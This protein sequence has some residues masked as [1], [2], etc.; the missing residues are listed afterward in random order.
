MIHQDLRYALRTWAARPAFAVIAILTLALG[1]GANT[2]IFSLWN[3]VLYAALPG[4]ANPEQLVMLSN[5]NA[6]GSWTGRWNSR[7]DGPRAWVTYEEFERLR[8]NASAFAALMATQSSL[9]TWRASIDG[10]PVE[11]MRGRLVSG[12]FFDLLGARAAIGRLFTIAEDSG[13]PSIA[14]ISHAFWQQRFGGRPDVLGKTLTIRDTPVTIVGV[15]PPRFVGET[16]AQLPDLWMPLRLQPRVLPPRDWLRDTPPDKVMWL[17]VFGRLKPGVTFAHAE[18][19]ANAIL[20]SSLETFYGA[21]L[22]DRRSEFL[23]QQLRLTAAPSGTT[24]IRNE[25]SASL[26]MLLASVGVLMLIACANLANLLLA[27][28]AA[29]QPE[30]AVRLSLGASRVRLVRQLVTES[31]ALAVMGAL[32]GLGVAYGLHNALV[33]ML[34]GADPRFAMAFTITL[35][36]AGFVVAATLA[37]A[38]MFGL[39]PAWQL[40]RSDLGARLNERGR[41][42]G[43][44]RRE[45]R[46]GRWL[47]GAQ[48][49]LS[50]P[51]LVGAGLLV[52][53]VYNLQR[54]DLGFERDGLLLA[55]VDLGLVASDTTR[56]DRVLRDVDERLGRI[57]GVQAVSFSQLG[58]F[59]GGQSTIAIEVEGY[60]WPSNT[61]RE[62][63]L[64][65]VG[66]DYM[67]TLG[68]PIRLGRDIRETDARDTP[69][70]CVVNEAFAR[71][72]FGGRHPLGLRVTTVDDS[73][74]RKAYEVVGMAGDARMHDLRGEV[75]PRFYLPA[76]QRNSQGTGRTF[77]IRS[78]GALPPASGSIRETIS[79]VDAALSVTSIV[80]VDDQLA[81][82]TAQDRTSAMLATAFGIVALTLAAIGLYGVLSYAVARR[83]SEIAIRIA[84]G[85]QGGR[86]IAMILRESLGVVLAGL[87][88]GGALA[89][90][91][92]RMIAARL[93][94][95]APQDP[96][97][98]MTATGLL[99]LVALIAA[100]LP[101]RRAS[102]VQPMAV[103]H[104]G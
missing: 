104:Q 93:Y 16:S 58:L 42:A 76:E 36:V 73:G 78:A 2:A 54:P 103:L 53:T 95:V 18:A 39:L 56:R 26:T 90:E 98:L 84:L 75:E 34:R 55:H 50:L 37:T 69:A 30:I 96:M 60:E 79:S 68:I 40:T 15:T 7:V 22:D 66:A 81:P 77:L 17:H 48:L 31:V 23:D 14:V 100:F 92:S 35:P 9:V 21:A 41:G 64:D 20:R 13:E 29:R 33:W 3:G 8:D 12:G 83:A 91:G 88:V 46:S 74:L 24:S 11:E 63:S 57:P 1:L 70:V 25:F 87:A 47:V 45:L 51:L 10:G 89:Y 49:A 72:F 86:V 94:G 99:L 27:R 52:Q 4:V 62:T 61:D 82:Q 32:A 19:E 101:A 28:G 65:R 71:R 102:K 97:T 67:T 5:P 44:S 59:S 43:G 38:L 85:A 80:S 6:I